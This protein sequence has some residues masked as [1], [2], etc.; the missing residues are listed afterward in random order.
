[1]PTAIFEETEP[2]ICGVIGAFNVH[3]SVFW[4]TRVELSLIAE[5]TTTGMLSWVICDYESNTI[6]YDPGQ[7]FRRR[8]HVDPWSRRA[9]RAT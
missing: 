3:T 7:G 2:R 6:S 1:M 5:N 4:G 9:M 8:A